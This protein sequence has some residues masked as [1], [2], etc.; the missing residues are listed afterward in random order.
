MAAKH[1]MTDLRE[2]MFEVIEGL[3]DKS[4]SVQEGQA[5]ANAGQVIINSAK[6]EI[7]FLKVTNGGELL[8]SGFVDLVREPEPLLENGEAHQEE[9][10]M[11]EHEVV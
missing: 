10:P 4:I 3:K 9:T 2:S 1:N 5:I 6:V 7:D 11:F 8:G